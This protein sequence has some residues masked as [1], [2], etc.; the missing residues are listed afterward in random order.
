MKKKILF[1]GNCQIGAISQY[2]LENRHLKEIFEIILCDESCAP[3]NVWRGDTSNFATWTRENKPIQKDIFPVVHE[4]LKQADIFIFQAVEKG[5]IPELSTKYLCDN[6]SKGKQICIPNTRMFIY[7]TDYVSLK[8]YLNY[9][10]TKVKNSQDAAE[11]AKFI[12]NSED[13]EL[14]NILEQD[15]PISTK[16]VGYR[17]ENTQRAAEDAKTYP[18]FIHMGD[19]IREN[20][21]TK[22]LAL[23]HNHMNTYY[24][25][26]VLEKLFDVLGLS[27]LEINTENLLAPGHVQ[28]NPK[29][30]KFFQNYFPELDFPS[31]KNN[32]DL[33]KIIQ[34]NHLNTQ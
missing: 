10:Q 12:K 29:E 24:Y 16:F 22:L 19:F 17:N 30:F 15:Y 2:F 8:P 18:N 21:K 7:C 34:K 5:H 6:I 33:N 1:Y 4:K 9:A 3:M 27:G 31:P 32:I 26:A 13:P 25:V 23:Q 14:Y 11:L 28:V 20:Y